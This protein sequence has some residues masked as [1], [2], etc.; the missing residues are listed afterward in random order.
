MSQA[1][2]IRVGYVLEIHSEATEGSANPEHC[3]V[4]GLYISE[5]YNWKYTLFCW[6][7]WLREKWFIS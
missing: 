6:I 7:A 1:F 4:L 2:L 5:D 3:E